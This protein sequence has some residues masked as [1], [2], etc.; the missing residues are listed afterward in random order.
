MYLTM[1]GVLYDAFTTLL[2]LLCIFFLN[3][4]NNFVI[5]FIFVILDPSFM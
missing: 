3:D 1:Y 4:H 2:L 5:L